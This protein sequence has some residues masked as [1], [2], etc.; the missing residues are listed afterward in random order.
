MD[1]LLMTLRVLIGDVTCS[2]YSD[3]DL[4]RLLAVSTNLVSKEVDLCVNYTVYIENP[5]IEPDPSDISLINLVS[6]RAAILLLESELRNM[7]RQ[8]ISITDGPS[9][10]ELN[11]VFKNTEVLL[12]SLKNDYA[13][14]KL[15]YS[16]NKGQDGRQAVI[17]PT[18]VYRGQCR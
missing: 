2:K 3:L 18:T 4:K 13:Q 16:M 11:N 1:E 7:A 5:S 6:Q 15:E 10:I 9:K 12:Q 8:S 17:T 14:S